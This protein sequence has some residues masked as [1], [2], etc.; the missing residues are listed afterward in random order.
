M[1]K[2]IHVWGTP[3]A[4]ETP[5]SS[6]RRISDEEALAALEA[7]QPGWLHQLQ[8]VSIAMGVPKNGWF[9]LGKSLSKMDDD[10][11]YPHLWETPIHD[12][13]IDLWLIIQLIIHQIIQYI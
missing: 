12:H 4:M 7:L 1:K 10:W 2:T 11:G 6:P 9:L 8:G 3:M 13:R 5:K